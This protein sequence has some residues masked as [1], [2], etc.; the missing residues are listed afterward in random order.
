VNVRQIAI[1]GAAIVLALGAFVW[2]RGAATPN[3]ATQQLAQA[4]A[5]PAS[6]QVLVAKRDLAVGER[7]TADAVGWVDWPQGSASQAFYLKSAAPNAA[8]ELTNGVV[9]VA[10][11]TGEP[12]TSQKVVVTGAASSTMAA[13]VTPGMRATAISINPETA[14]AGFILPNDRVDI[15]LT[16]EM[17]ITVNGQQTTRSVSSTVLENV[18]VLA[19]D[20]AMTPAKDA[21]TLPGSTATVELSGEDAEKLRLADKLG[22]LSLS[23]RSYADAGGP[24]MARLDTAAM[25]QPVPPPQQSTATPSPSAASAGQVTNTESGGSSNNTVVGPGSATAP[26]EVKVYRGGQ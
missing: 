22:D 16:R 18:R 13:L 17:N 7:I 14:V 15:V 5:A 8:E 19:I 3:Q 1:V 2:L 9:R 20:Q 24:T 25:A 6:V 11:V 12:L 10:M 23:L 4:T 26:S 21:N